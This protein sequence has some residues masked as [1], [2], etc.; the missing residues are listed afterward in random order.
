[1]NYNTLSGS[2]KTYKKAE[3]YASGQLVASGDVPNIA[4]LC[5]VDTFEHKRLVD[6]VCFGIH[7]SGGIANVHNVPSYGFLNKTNPLTAKY[8]AS[9]ARVTASSAEAII[10]T[11]LIDGVVIIADCDVTVTGLLMGVARANCPALVVPVG[12]V[13]LTGL[14]L[15]DGTSALSLPG[16][17]AGGK[18]NAIKSE[19]ILKTVRCR[20][21]LS[22]KLDSA[23][24]FF[25]L[26]ECMGFS[27]AGASLAPFDSAP[28]HRIAIQTGEQI[29]ISA[30]D[31]LAPKKFLT[32]SNFNN[33]VALCLAVG[34]SISAIELISSLVKMFEGRIAHGLINEMSSKTPLFLSHTDSTTEKITELGGINSILKTLSSIPKLIEIDALNYAGEKIK[35]TLAEIELNTI[36][37][38]AKTAKISL[39]KGSAVEDGGYV[40]IQENTPVSISG[41]AWVYQNLEDADKALLSG[42][43][44]E[45]S[46]VVVHN[47]VEVDVSVLA[48]AIQGMGKADSVAILTDGFADK[49]NV[50]VVT[51]CTPTSMDNEAFANI[52]NG[53]QIEIDLSKGR[54]NTSVLSKDLKNRGK[55]NAA[56]KPTTY[57]Q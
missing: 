54:V 49:T 52:Q 10:K 55:R 24:T 12:V 2:A 28:M 42:N 57:F 7:K 6:S 48:N 40:Q 14:R 21:R 44:P 1:M 4:V 39:I 31:I 32:R 45:N 9:F 26:V 50:L 53:D 47:C 34:G 17:L 19:E 35:N 13:G 51:R 37:P 20:K 5:A 30:K 33:T 56:K 8:A 23:T 43:I 27:V 38:F 16:K 25:V 46:I 41:K 15:Q 22:T 36:E 11:N 29:C 18:I 3:S